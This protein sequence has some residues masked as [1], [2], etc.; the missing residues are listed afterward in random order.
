MNATWQGDA[1][2][3]LAPRYHEA[4]PDLW[5]QFGNSVEELQA[6]VDELSTQDKLKNAFT[7]NLSIGKLIYINR[8]VSLNINLNVNNILN[9][10]NIATYAYQ[11]GR[12]DVK[13]WNREKYPNRYTYAQGTRVFLNVGVRF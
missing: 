12:I 7:L 11:Q 8:K 1:Y 6:K 4:L 9:N 3:N 13:E 5:E 10:K 2:V